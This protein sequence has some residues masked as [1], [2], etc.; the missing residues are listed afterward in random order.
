MVYLSRLL[1]IIWFIVVVYLIFSLIISLNKKDDRHT[2]N[3]LVGKE[4]FDDCK[5]LVNLEESKKLL[6]KIIG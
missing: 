1:K 5:K 2:R 4:W 3:I 6:S